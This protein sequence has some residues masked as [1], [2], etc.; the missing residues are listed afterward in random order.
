MNTVDNSHVDVA[1]I[2]KDVPSIDQERI[3]INSRRRE[4][5]EGAFAAASLDCSAR[6]QD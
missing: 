3:S 6:V 1:S 2:D 4:K 5:S